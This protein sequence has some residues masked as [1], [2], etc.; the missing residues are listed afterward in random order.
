M[1]RCNTTLSLVLLLLL[2]C[3]HNL[4]R[5]MSARAST[6]HLYA[7]VEHGLATGAAAAKKA[8]CSHHKSAD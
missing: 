5:Q 3:T 4:C 1:L 6:P 2:S 8:S 7:A